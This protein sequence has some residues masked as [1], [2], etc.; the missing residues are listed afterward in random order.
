MSPAD[1]STTMSTSDFKD[2]KIKQLRDD[3]S[4]WTTWK[5]IITTAF[6]RRRLMR[7]LNGT[8][9]RPCI[10]VEANGK[11]FEKLEEAVPATTTTTTSTPTPVPVPTRQ[12]SSDET[13]RAERGLGLELT[14]A[15]AKERDE[16]LDI[17]DAN[18]ATIREDPS[19]QRR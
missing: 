10:Y 19:E 4:N 17:Y 5:D 2:L 11:Y 12:Q 18:E 8:A 15:K 1:Y 6:Q 3:G 16:Q 13:E 14:E 9:K 7:H